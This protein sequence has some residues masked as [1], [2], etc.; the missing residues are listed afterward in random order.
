MAKGKGGSMKDK[1]K[2]KAER[3]MNRGGSSYLALPENTERFKP[4]KGTFNLDFLPY[5][6]TVDTHPEVD[7]GEFWY[8]R[9]FFVH[10]GIG[11]DSNAFIC[12]KT[13]KKPCPICDHVKELFNSDNDEDVELA[14]NIKAKE[15]ELYNV[16]NLDDQDKGVQLFE[17]SYHLF[18]KA[19]DEEINEGD[20][21]LGGFAELE[22]GKTVSV[23]FRKKTFG[24]NEFFETRKIEFDERDDYDEDILD[25][26]YD[27]DELL[28]IKDYKT[29]QKALYDLDDE[30]TDDEEEEE[31]KEEKPKKS[32]KKSSKKADKKSSKSSKKSEKDDEEDEE[33]EE[34]E[35]KP[36]KSKSKKSSKKSSTKKKGK[37]KVGAKECPHGHT[38]GEDVDEY[39][40][41]G[42]C[43]KWADCQEASESDDDEDE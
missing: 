31:E 40:E 25:D 36:K 16:I 8:Q 9:T 33:D 1:A 4:K 10:Y 37:K 32:S 3:N 13:I 12:P 30:D 5:R 21:D 17:Y 41:C 24:K 20:D 2:K 19:L 22:G 39:D 11:S 7:E 35:E 38:F 18:G 23:S 34:E 6:V 26:V 15:R 29:L 27:L 43:E 42:D 28:V 14:K